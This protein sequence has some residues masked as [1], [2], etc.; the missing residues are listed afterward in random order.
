[1][2]AV[3]DH[4]LHDRTCSNKSRNA[5][6]FGLAN[7]GL[8][9]VWIIATASWGLLPMN[10]AYGSYRPQSSQME[11]R[12]R[13]QGSPLAPAKRVTRKTRRLQSRLKLLGPARILAKD[14][15][16]RKNVAQGIH[17]I[18]SAGECRRTHPQRGR[19]GS[20]DARRQRHER[21]PSAADSLDYFPTPPWATRAVLHELLLPLRLSHP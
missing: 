16:I 12:P 9:L 17:E 1:M 10:L 2:A 15:M 14:G 11:F 13:E 21:A 6:L 8:W 18:V 4:D 3:R 7:Q 5:W 19:G 20:H